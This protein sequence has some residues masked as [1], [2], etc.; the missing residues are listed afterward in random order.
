VLRDF[1]AKNSQT[2]ES[3]REIKR[4]QTVIASADCNWLQPECS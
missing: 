2:V 4:S 3:D 1:A